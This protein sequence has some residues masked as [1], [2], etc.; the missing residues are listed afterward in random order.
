MGDGPLQVLCQFVQERPSGIV[1]EGAELVFGGER[2]FPFDAPTN[3]KSTGGEG[4]MYTLHQAYIAW[5]YQADGALATYLK[6][7]RQNKWKGIKTTD[8]FALV[9][10]IKGEQTAAATTQLVG[11]AAAAGAAA[12]AAAAA[13]AGAAAAAAVEAGPVAATDPLPWASERLRRQAA[14]R[15][16]RRCFR[17]RWRL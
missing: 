10:Y 9:R 8:R 6:T 11:E 7:V 14:C 16:W 5:K 13:A 3:F 15:C 1:V 12:G 4:E 17:R 2:R